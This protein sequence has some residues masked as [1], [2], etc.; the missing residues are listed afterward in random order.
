[1]HLASLVRWTIVNAL[2]MSPAMHSSVL[3]MLS[4]TSTPATKD[5]N[6]A[7]DSD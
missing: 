1:M 6:R 3:G 7:I 4:S 5:H 2:G